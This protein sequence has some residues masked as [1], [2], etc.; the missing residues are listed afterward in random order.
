MEVA[1]KNY[2]LFGAAASAV[3]L[4]T[5]S[6]DFAG[7]AGTGQGGRD[8]LH[9]PLSWCALQGSPAAA[10]PNITPEGS[11]TAD[12]STDAILWRRHE[13]P[14]DNIYTPQADI[15]FRSAINNVWGTLNFPI[16]ADP[17]TGTAQGGDV[18]GEDNTV[19]GVGSE[20]RTV[21]Q[22]C[23]T[24][25]TNLGRGGIGITAVNVDLFHDANGNYCSQDAAGTWTC[26]PIGWGGCARPVGSN[27][28]STPFNANIM[29]ADNRYLYPT[30]ADR[31]HPATTA[32]PT[33]NVSY[34]FTDPLDQLVGHELGHALGLDHR[35]DA[36]ALM[37]PS[38]ND[39][40]GDS[41]VDNVT[42]NAT[43]VA[44]VRANALNVPGLET[45][46]PG[47]IEPGRFVATTIV[48]DSEEQGL[49]AQFDLVSVDLAIDK[50]S[51]MAFVQV[52]LRGV[53]DGAKDPTGKF[54]VALDTIEG[55]AIDPSQIKSI[56]A[57]MNEFTAADSFIEMEFSN[58][59]VRGLVWLVKD[60]KL[61][62]QKLKSRFERRQMIMFP[63]Y[64]PPSV[65]GGKWFI[66]DEGRGVAIYDIM[67]AILPAT[68][69]NLFYGKPFEVQVASMQDEKVVDLLDSRSVKKSNKI[70]ENPSFP[71]CFV[72]AATGPGGS[73]AIHVEG[74]LVSKPL[75][76]LVGPK[77]V[78]H[79]ATDASGNADFDLPVPK[80][81]RPGL[82][83]V[84][85]GNDG[86]ALTADC[87]VLVKGREKFGSFEPN[88]RLENMLAMLDG[89]KRVI[90][91]IVQLLDKSGGEDIELNALYLDLL[92]RY[93]GLAGQIEKEMVK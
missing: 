16:I 83:L 87:V 49:P 18:R 34:S 84:T 43:E 23:A 73:S 86:T 31:T 63:H 12:T 39:T 30:V 67:A 25:W 17:N 36:A 47:V 29:I 13:R 32:D 45:D 5:I 33:G 52:S 1:M 8:V 46:P 89:H 37:R 50:L 22:N 79:G 66:P 41:R 4:F 61:I 54:W 57:P 40:N 24:A 70:L 81:A 27:T 20:F 11:T 9:V 42:L 44:S 72:K 78:Y 62:Q 85:V 76:A 90:A 65:P 58:G 15:T 48:D 82:H 74:L 19:L 10:S 51:A 59:E 64:T 91:Q 77:E 88:S 75:H 2:L 55:S 60:G 7:A 21:I 35:N 53:F 56:G 68:D 69:L 80:D 92:R 93:A 28:C 14:T 3:L 38:Q 71:H 6:P 26:T